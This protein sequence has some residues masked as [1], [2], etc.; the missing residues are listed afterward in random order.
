[1]PENLALEY[2]F[3]D[4]VP[5]AAEMLPVAEGVYWLRMPLPFH[6][7]HIN[8]YLLRGDSGWVI[9]DTG[10]H[11]EETRLLWERV[12]AEQ[13]N[14]L[15]VERVLVT[16][17]HPDHIGM[18]GWL[19]RHWDV[20]LWMSR[21]DFYLCKTLASDL[22]GDVPDGA[23]RFY[24]RAGFTEEQLQ[25]YKSRFG[26]FGSA[27]YPLPAGYRRLRDGERPGF[28]GSEWEVVVGRGH[29]PEHV[30]LYN[31]DKK[32]FISGDQVL[33]KIS[34]NVSVFP[35][36]PMNNPLEEWLES[37]HG[38][39]ERVPDDVLVLPSHGRPFRNMHKRL[40]Q[41]IEG[42]EQGLEKLQQMCSEKPRRAVDVF[43]ALFRR[44]IDQDLLL[45]AVG[46]SIA[47]LNCLHHRKSVEIDEDSGV[48][49]YRQA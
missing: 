42:H 25:H 5:G 18:S 19:T 46:E 10:I 44:E 30:C 20:D 40:Q 33:P 31:R 11:T 48:Y 17:L 16:H 7:N 49:W 2:P 15:P 8:V 43:P 37:C 21:T 4:A 32:L 6:L 36:E 45:M 12:F 39:Q 38:L 27:I 35:S 13:L 47:H 28:A 41:L 14:G 1:M 26:R 29:A 22:P 3:G 23:I 24:E 34:S 9:V